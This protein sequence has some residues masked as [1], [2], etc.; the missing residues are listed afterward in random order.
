[1]VTIYRVNIAILG[2][3]QYCKNKMNIK[4]TFINITIVSLAFIGLVAAPAVIYNSPAYAEEKATEVKVTEKKGNLNCSILPDDICNPSDK[5][6]SVENSGVFVI[7]V[8]VLN[9]MSAGIGIVAVGGI[10]FQ[11]IRYASAAS[12]QGQVADA[13]QNILNIVIGLVLYG[14]MFVLLN[15]LIPGGIFR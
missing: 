15:F 3:I 7:L 1:M 10:V 8:W 14:L 5:S 12:N 13:K 4:Q 2:E 6:S 9:I 11:A